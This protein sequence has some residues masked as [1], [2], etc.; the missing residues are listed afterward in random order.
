MDCSDSSKH[1]LAL[2]GSNRCRGPCESCRPISWG[3]WRGTSY[4]CHICSRSGCAP[5]M[6]IARQDDVMYVHTLFHLEASVCEA[7]SIASDWAK[8]TKT[9]EIRYGYNVIERFTSLC[10]TMRMKI[11]IATPRVS[12]SY[13]GS[14]GTQFQ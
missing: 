13:R 5:L 2:I 8:T 7:E 12:E 9:I 6:H 14:N 4:G 11:P 10:A 3:T 1:R